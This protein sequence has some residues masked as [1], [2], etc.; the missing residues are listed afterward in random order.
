MKKII[1]IIC[2]VLVCSFTT[3]VNAN[4]ICNDG[5]VSNTCMD[6]HKGCC[7]K[8]DG[9]TPGG[10]TTDSTPSTQALKTTA[11][12]TT[13]VITT[14]RLTTT[15]TTTTTTVTTTETTTIEST[16]ATTTTSSIKSDSSQEIA[17]N[18][19]DSDSSGAAGAFGFLTLC[20][21]AGGTIAYCVN[22]NKK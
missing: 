20:G 11:T 17:T 13:R 6:C 15:T 22:K 18:N 4:I 2:L 19:N 9:C 1:L 7:S 16:T 5:T 3:T 14:T 10:P 21:L 8:H 12:T